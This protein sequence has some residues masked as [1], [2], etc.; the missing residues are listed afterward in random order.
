MTRSTPDVFELNYYTPVI[1]P[2]HSTSVRQQLSR[3]PLITHRYHSMAAL[4]SEVLASVTTAFRIIGTSTF[5][6]NFE[7]LV[8]NGAC[9][10]TNL[11]AGYFPSRR[12]AEVRYSSIHCV[13]KS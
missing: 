8:T 4:A 7:R 10:G 6:A 12:T 11:L 13:V 3:Y 5:E 9:H 2:V 1:I